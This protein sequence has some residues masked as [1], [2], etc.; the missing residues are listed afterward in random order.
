MAT[1]MGAFGYGVENGREILLADRADEFASACIRLLRD[2]ELRE[3]LSGEP[4]N[5]FWGM[6]M[7]F[8]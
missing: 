3:A 6:D 8:I 1:S 5:A 2:P 7:G 4:I